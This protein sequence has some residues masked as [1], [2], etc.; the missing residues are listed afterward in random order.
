MCPDS[1]HDEMR[2]AP[3]WHRAPERA[4]T[5]RAHLPSYRPRCWPRAPP[6][7][8][9][10]DLIDGHMSDEMETGCTHVAGKPSDLIDYGPQSEYGG[11][12][13]ACL[14]NPNAVYALRFA[15]AELR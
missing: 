11:R 10:A 14:R 5:H 3:P 4:A 15:P 7:E 6:R 13:Y 8:H 2:Q 1:W 9:P 12:R